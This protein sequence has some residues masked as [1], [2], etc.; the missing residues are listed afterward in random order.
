MGRVLFLC[1]F[2]MGKGGVSYLARRVSASPE[3]DNSMIGYRYGTSKAARKSDGLE[4]NIVGRRCVEWLLLSTCLVPFLG[5]V[6]GFW[7]RPP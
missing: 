4:F 1:L 7:C 5:M 2:V 6:Q 3:V